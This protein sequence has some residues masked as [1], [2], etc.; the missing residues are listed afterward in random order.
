MAV[1][2]LL[3][4]DVGHKTPVVGGLERSLDGSVVGHRR[5][6]VV[7]RMVA[8]PVIQVVALVL[9]RYRLVEGLTARL[10]AHL[11]PVAGGCGAIVGEQVAA[12][13]VALLPLLIG[14]LAAYALAGG[15]VKHSAKEGEPLQQEGH[16]HHGIADGLVVLIHVL[17]AIDGR[18]SRRVVL[19]A[20][21]ERLLAYLK[22]HERGLLP[23][24]QH[25]DLQFRGSLTVV[26]GQTETTAV[27]QSRL[28]VVASEVVDIALHGIEDT[29]HIQVVYLGL[30]GLQVFK[31][32]AGDGLQERHHVGDGVVHPPLARAAPLGGLV[33]GEGAGHDVLFPSAAQPIDGGLR[34]GDDALR[35]YIIKG[36]VEQLPS[37]LGHAVDIDALRGIDHQCRVG[38]HLGHVGGGLR[39]ADI[40]ILAG[41]GGEVG[42]GD[43]QR[44]ALVVVAVVVLQSVDAAHIAH[45]HRPAGGTGLHIV[46]IRQRIE[47]DCKRSRAYPVVLWFGFRHC[48][49]FF[50][51]S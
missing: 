32:G 23:H 36:R 2:E 35:V 5:R 19:V 28:V 14:H 1:V 34:R 15:I 38:V 29:R 22:L 20:A 33:A 17:H 44:P 9:R 31:G 25:I 42:L 6:G 7:A 49:I 39:Y 13:V 12:E 24:L 46:G 30:C 40:H 47:R 37:V 16:L 18:A 50:R 48:S 3:R 10:V 26:V 45:D 8:L 11:P 51:Q 4:A 21:D 27:E 43:A 41:R